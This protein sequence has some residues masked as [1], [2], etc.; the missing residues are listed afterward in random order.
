[1]RVWNFNSYSEKNVF[2][3]KLLDLNERKYQNKLDTKRLFKYTIV[4]K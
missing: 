4:L 1:M 3:N 2:E